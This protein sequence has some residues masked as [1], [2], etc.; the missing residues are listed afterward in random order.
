MTPT[1]TGL[2]GCPSDYDPEFRTIEMLDEIADVQAAAGIR[3]ATEIKLD[4]VMACRVAVR[5]CLLDLAEDL[6]ARGL[7]LMR[8]YVVERPPITIEDDE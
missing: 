4:I 6:D 1:E 8:I 5:E 7:F 2:Y 3:G